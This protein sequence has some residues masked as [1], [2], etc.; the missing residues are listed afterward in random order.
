MFNGL[1]DIDWASMEHAYGSAAEVPSLLR[2]MRSANAEERTEA[3]GEFYGA[4]YHQNSV[5]E[6]TAASLP[7]LF[8]MACDTDTPD[9]AAVVQL[10]VGIGDDALSRLDGDYLDLPVLEAAVAHMRQ[11]ADALVALTA[12]PDPE[13]RRAAIP[14]LGLF[15]DD[16]GGRR[17][18][19][20]LHERLAT[21]DGLMERL[22]VVE[23]TA[24]LALRL[25]T[26]AEQART[27]LATAAADPHRDRSTRLAALTQHA[28]CAPDRI[29]PGI[30]PAAVALLDEIGH[31]AP[32]PRTWRHPTP[33][34]PRGQDVPPQVIAGFDH[35]DRI[36][37]VHAVT[38]RTLRTLHETLDERVAWRSELLSAQLRSPDP[39]TRLDA[40]RMSG[41]LMRTW[42][43]DYSD[44]VTLV[45]DQLDNGD[46]ELA[47]AAADVLDT[48]HAIAEPA[49]EALA[50]YVAS[51]RAEHGPN[52]WA[53]PDAEVR[54][55][56]QAAVC[57]LARFGDVR[58]L[59][60]VLV[61]L[62]GGV[63]AWRA[64][65]AAAWL[66]EASGTLVPALVRHL[67]EADLAASWFE[68]TAHALLDALSRLGDTSAVPVI[69]EILEVAVRDGHWGTA[70]A[71]L[72]ALT[73]FGVDAAAAL[74]PVRR[75]TSS[76]E[77]D[78]RPPVHEARART[79]AVETLHALG[80]SPD[81]VRAAIVEVALS[82]GPSWIRDLGDLLG[83]VGP[84]VPPALVEQLRQALTDDYEWQRVHAA[85]A[86]WDLFGEPETPVVLETLTRAWEKNSATANHTLACLERMGPAAEPAA[87][88]LATALS[89]PR[90]LAWW[91]DIERD[92]NM[93]R[94]ARRILTGFDR[95]RT[96]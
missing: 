16:D 63:D 58:A 52:V 59:P 20:L 25:P 75:L 2:A 51:R 5:Y 9:R 11:H 10:I 24:T 70:E 64:F 37:R 66:R 31:G 56:H 93:Q 19:A 65:P 87:P 15:V 36:N 46:G 71:A 27:R 4:V 23:A 14:A 22:V 53:H 61:A 77:A 28:R 45:A 72:K 21:E 39:G 29:R 47:A 79:S 90:R 54:R 74:P 40:V 86:L 48:C 91:A 34:T 8:E 43:G 67:R 33:E 84:P 94:S 32:S 96:R 92:E 41:D 17:A 82:H 89:E 62:D 26:V 7:F 1:D 81:E 85:T 6:P 3:F 69:V 44:L 83:R 13:V 60:C 18:D 42:R 80:G 57:A 78:A 68:G 88:L 73:R 38:T 95:E 55:A 50:A 35:L 30:I 49:R 76:L 12:D